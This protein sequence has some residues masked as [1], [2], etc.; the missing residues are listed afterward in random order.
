MHTAIIR[1]TILI[2]IGLPLLGLSDVSNPSIEVLPHWKKGESFR[3][4]VTRARAKSAD[5]KSTVT[6]KTHT[7]FTIEVLN[8]NDNGYLVGWTAGETKFDSPSQSEPSF[9]RKVVNLMNGLQIILEID[10]HGTIRGV[11]NWKEIKAVALKS[12]E[13]LATAEDLQKEKPDKALMSSLR[14]QWESMLGTKEQVEELCT[15]EAQV[16]F[17]VLGR[18]YAHNNP[19]EYEDRLPNPL[20]GDAFPTHATMTLKTFDKQS[21]RAVITWSQTTDPQ[22][23][24]RILES[25][26]KEMS[27]RLGKKPLDGEVPKSISMQDHAEIVVDVTTGWVRTLTHAR[28]VNFGTRAQVDTTSIIR[29]AK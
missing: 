22:Q 9:L 17:M 20:G 11:Q 21:D 2:L 28:S 6:G 27:A 15:R 26:I 12:L 29:T 23:A 3:L 18:G 8:V 5:G 4:D 19:Y 7:H 14:A 10:S 1:T 16:Y 25:M 13:A 24:A